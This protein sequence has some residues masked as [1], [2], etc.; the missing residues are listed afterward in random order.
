MTP[1]VLPALFDYPQ[2]AAFGRI[3]PKNK[4]YAFGK[5]SRRVR[6]H[7]T[8]E[9]AQI[10]W[11]YKLAPETI[12]LPAKPGVSEIQIFLINLKPGIAE[13]SEDVLRCIDKAIGFPIIF[14]L[15]AGDRIQAIAAYKRPSEADSAK[16]VIG[17]Y[18]ATDWLP[19]DTPRSPL[20]VALDLASLYE[21]L[22]RQLMPT[23]ARTDESLQAL[24]ERHSRIRR[25]ERECR[26]LEARLS[27]EKQFNRKVETNA[28]LRSLKAELKTLTG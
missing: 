2:K 7:F 19:A 26:Q 15:T 27:R 18:F 17:D 21:Q 20:P 9:V 22:L 13:L 25:V 4:V 11:Q 14:E 10:V 6:D 24:A 5:P 28:Q 16:W 23:P 12:N 8:T 3:L 1:P